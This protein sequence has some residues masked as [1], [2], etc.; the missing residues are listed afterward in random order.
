MCVCVCASVCVSV[1][2]CECVCECVCVCVCVFVL[3]CTVASRVYRSTE[4]CRPLHEDRQQTRRLNEDNQHDTHN[5]RCFDHSE[6]AVGE[7]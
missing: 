6:R 3:H 1:C 5:R 4:K 7:Y 2:V